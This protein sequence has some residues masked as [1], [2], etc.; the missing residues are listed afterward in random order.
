MDPRRPLTLLLMTVL[1][2]SGAVQP[3]FA[4]PAFAQQP[5]FEDPPSIGPEKA[6][7]PEDESPPHSNR[8]EKILRGW[9][10]LYIEAGPDGEREVDAFFSLYHRRYGGPEESLRVAPFYFS[11]TDHVRDR[12]S[13]LFLPFYYADRKGENWSWYSLPLSLGGGERGWYR[14]PIWLG[15]F[16]GDSGEGF[17]EDRFG[18]GPIFDVYGRRRDASGRSF[19][20]LGLGS[21]GEPGHSFLPFFRYSTGSQGQIRESAL[22]PLYH[23]RHRRVDSTDQN[24][25]LLPFLGWWQRTS[26]EKSSRFFLPLLASTEG[27]PDGYRASLFLGLWETGRRNEERWVRFEPFF[28]RR[29]G[30]AAGDYHVLRLFGRA[31]KDE[32]NYRSVSILPPIGHFESDDYGYRH[33]FFPF[34]YASGTSDAVP[35]PS[36]TLLVA[37][38]YYG[39]VNEGRTRRF[40][41]PSYYSDAAEGATTRVIF[42][43]YWQ[44]EHEGANGRRGRGYLH[45]FPILASVHDA[46]SS[47]SSWVGPL[48]VHR[49]QYRRPS[50]ADGVASSSSVAPGSDVE[51]ES[52]SVLWPLFEHSSGDDYWHTHALPL[53]WGTREGEN[54]LDVFAPFYLRSKSPTSTHH[55]FLPA[56]GRYTSTTAERKLERDFYA[57]GALIRS[58][59]T[60]FDA[61]RLGSDLAPADSSGERGTVS[62]SL[63]GP[64]AG[65]SHAKESDDHHSRLLPFWWR[66]KE[67]D[68]DLALLFPLYFR[69][70]HTDQYETK[71]GS[72]ER[73][74]DLTLAGGN[75]WVDYES[76]LRREWGILYPFSRF[77]EVETEDGVES[78]AN[79][80]GLFSHVTG[81]RAGSRWRASPLFFSATDS[82]APSGHEW[83]HLFSNQRGEW[84]ERQR[85]MPF[86][87]LREREGDHRRTDLLFSVFHSESDDESSTDWALP[88]YFRRTFEGV[89]DQRSSDTIFFPFYY[90]FERPLL[91]RSQFSI[92][93][94]LYTRIQD[95]EAEA[96]SVRHSVLGPIFQ[97][98]T[99]PGY[100]SV[101]W[102]PVFGTESWESGASSWN[103]SLLYRQRIAAPKD[104][105]DGLWSRDGYFGFELLRHARGANT[106]T[107]MLHPFF[108]GYHRDDTREHVEWNTLFYL[109]RYRRDGDDVRYS[110]FGLVHG[111][112][113]A[114]R[115]WSTVFPLYYSDDFKDDRLPSFSLPSALHLVSRVENDDESR[116][117]LLGYLAHG[118]SN[119]KNDDYEFRILYRGVAW[120]RQGSFRE[121]VIEPLF[122]YESDER[123]GA[124]YL[125]FGKFIYIAK[126][127]DGEA[128][129]KRYLLG[130]P[131]QW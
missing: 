36:S 111:S 114:E 4:P 56:Y 106:S 1:A 46:E 86:L 82:A 128:P 84:G 74:S 31:W 83:W 101:S 63:F 76:D 129:V 90:G 30:P 52:H 32:G 2:V 110:A 37:P 112:S 62:W 15:L 117:S 61:E 80:L 58:E 81:P 21:W 68:R 92:L 64:L 50:E 3:G 109:N 87:Y 43:L 115:D 11:N 53:Y 44:S 85:I 57:G 24:D 73:R 122:N 95:G 78:S 20:L 35:T 55:W 16:R 17:R 60:E 13:S 124:G 5:P 99:S 28:S 12:S 79:I 131:L 77:S 72:L 6:A 34:Y 47:W 123:T 70:A 88:F 29:R 127:E 121:R 65:Y 48:Y 96:R 39:S 23:F 120:T 119:K 54:A 100:S 71:S 33:R 75:I 105:V 89:P 38:F 103:A 40:I 118:G 45:F 25:L 93:F 94:P 113:S 66:T 26:E 69:N 130:I 59:T 27:D 7:P 97:T 98:Q 14:A 104:E 67:G 116:W 19:D 9:P 126:Q 102:F 107:W 51:R 41:F 49:E 125:S 108:F 10:L 22:F 42:P 18:V 91:G 8:R